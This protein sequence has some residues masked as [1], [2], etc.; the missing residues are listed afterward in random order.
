VAY[1]GINLDTLQF[2]VDNGIF[3]DTVDFTSLV[4]ARLAT[5]N[6]LVK[7]LGRGVLKSK[8]KVSAHKFTETAK[9]AIENAGGEVVIL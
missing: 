9:L 2:M 7:I 1:Q 5:K 8:L 6:D 4:D 3:T